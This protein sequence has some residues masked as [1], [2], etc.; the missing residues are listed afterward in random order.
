MGRLAAQFAD[1]VRTL[2]TIVANHALDAEEKKLA[3]R[4]EAYAANTMG[5]L[6]IAFLNAAVIDFFASLSIAMLAVL[7]GLGHLKLIMIPGFSGLDLWQSLFI[8]MIAP[9]YFA[10]FRQF[11]EQ[12][13]AKADGLA[14]AQALDRLLDTDHGDQPRL[15]SIDFAKISLPPVGL[16]AIVGPS[17]AGKSTLL[18]RLAGIDSEPI[19]LASEISKEKISWISNDVYVSDGSLGE[20]IAPS[21]GASQAR[22]REV[23]ARIGLL[24]DELLPGG[25]EA[26]V[27]NFGGNLSGGQ[28]L[29]ISIARAL[30]SDSAI[31]A[32]EPTSK[33]DPHTASLVRG[34]LQD[35]AR[36]RLVI[37]A[38][39]DL[40]LA[41][42]AN[43]TID[44]AGG[45]RF[46]VAA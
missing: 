12:Y 18:R 25:L 31:L 9:E 41:G 43:L 35:M 2:P 29:R 22:I 6:R 44:L 14:A 42:R 15:P 28:R 27:E 3:V 19:E 32:D 30:L 46:E 16:V 26:R 5:V 8:L 10:P 34:A 1:R 40:A 24:D 38:T 45:R 17:G 39:H 23:A 33:L 36:S 37:V 7:L 11:A 21:P 20:V 13:H 4:L